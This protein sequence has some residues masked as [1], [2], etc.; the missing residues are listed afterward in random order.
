MLP[1][2][3]DRGSEFDVQNLQFAP[4]NDVETICSPLPSTLSV[5]LRFNGR[6]HRRSAIDISVEGMFVESPDH[7]PP[8]ELVQ[9]LIALPEGNPL[10]ALTTVERVVTPEEAAFC[11]GMPGMGLRFFMMDTRLRKRWEDYLDGVR[12]EAVPKEPDPEA[13]EHRVETPLELTR[14]VAPR[15]EGKFRVRLATKEKLA[16]FY[17]RDVSKGGMFLATTKVRPIGSRLRLAIKHPVSGREFPMEAEV[18]WVKEDG[19]EEER[20][21]GV[22][23][24][25]KNLKREE[26]FLRFINAG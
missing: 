11:G 13:R 18:R 19:P 24:V 25:G 8:G 12:E 21:M 5:C 2:T 26:A 4:G 17:T 16:E 23:L 14:R 3:A 15:K 20:G 22:Q 1:A 7:L 10:R 6:D 9:V